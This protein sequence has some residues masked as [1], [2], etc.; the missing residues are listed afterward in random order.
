MDQ[1]SDP[2]GPESNEQSRPPVA[3][4]PS[5]PPPPPAGY[6]PAPY[7]P[8]KGGG[9]MQKLAVTPITSVLLISIVMN[10]Y[11]FIIFQAQLSAGLSEQ[12]YIDGS[13]KHKIIIVEVTGTIDSSMAEYMRQAFD[14]LDQNTPDAVVL[15]V[16]SGGGGVTP[17]DQIWHY[18]SEFKATHPSVPVVASFGAVA[19]SGGYYVAAPADHIVCEQTGITGSI[20]VM[21]QAPTLGGLMEK[22]GVKWETMVAEGSPNKDT[23]NNIYRDWTEADR[24]VFEKLLN[25]AHARFVEVVTEG[26]SGK[27]DETAV[28]ALATGDIFTATEAEQNKLVDQ[29]GYLDDAIVKAATLANIPSGTE[30]TVTLIQ[31]PQPFNLLALLMHHG[32]HALAEASPEQV[33]SWLTDFSRVQIEYRIP[34]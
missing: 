18:F 19:A 9:V 30:P 23:A 13:A 4:A 24:A 20:G 26:R 12:A 5:A 15:R 31:R 14:Y 27:L 10:I 11:F 2:K 22:V 1:P 6:M 3:G 32:D 17:S 34:W 29:V 16:D 8:P 7:A 25:H 33:R 28:L 21:A